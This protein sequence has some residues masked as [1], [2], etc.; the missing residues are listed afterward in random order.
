MSGI[1]P[2]RFVDGTFPVSYGVPSMSWPTKRSPKKDVLIE[3]PDLEPTGPHSWAFLSGEP[4]DG[5]QQRI[6]WPDPK[7]GP[8]EITVYWGGVNGRWEPVGAQILALDLQPITAVSLRGLRWGQ[9]TEMAR[10]IVDVVF[11]STWTDI[12]GST[13]HTE[14]R[15]VYDP[16]RR[17]RPPKYGPQHFGE[18]A[19]I[20]REAWGSRNRTPTTAVK[21]YFK[22]SHTTAA[23]WVARCREM[24]PPLLPKN[25]G[26]GKALAVEPTKSRSTKR[27]RPDSGRSSRAKR[28]NA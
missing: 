10:P 1:F 5:K 4:E 7:R 14:R 3:W 27:A 13:Y 20:Y 28:K 11:G 8:W 16:P 12:D 26:R 18:V 19:R 23:K 2:G 21:N 15:V 6:L 22:V 9:I 24:D 25:P 17:G